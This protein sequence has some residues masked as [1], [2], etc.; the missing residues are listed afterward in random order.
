MD[1]F[2]KQIQDY[3]FFNIDMEKLV[4]GKANLISYPMLKKYKTIDQVLGKNK[5]C[6][7]LYLTGP[8]YGHWTCIFKTID[9]I[10][11]LEWFD[12]YGYKP[13]YELTFNAIDKNIEL[14]QDKPY[15]TNLLLKSKYEIIYNKKRLQILK[16][17]N[18]VCGRWVGMRLQFKYLPLDKF[19]DLFTKNKCYSA[20]WM[21]TALSSF[22]N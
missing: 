15:L 1:K 8:N 2:I 7:I 21:V 6:I 17:N 14:G 9:K 11:T 16:K 10:P 18:N 22:I 5:A 19:I 13:D 12:P 3:S 20:D 4:D